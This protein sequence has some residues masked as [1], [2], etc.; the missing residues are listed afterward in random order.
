MKKKQGFSFGQRLREA[1][2]LRG[3]PQDKLGVLIGL[4]EETAAPRISRYESD[5]MQAPIPTAQKLAHAL[6]VPLAYLYCESPSL[7]KL[8]LSASNLSEDELE[9]LIAKLTR[10]AQ[11]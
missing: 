1:R 5:V 11:K 4:D 10:K 8:L 3:L 9:Q 2:I 6:N 7:A